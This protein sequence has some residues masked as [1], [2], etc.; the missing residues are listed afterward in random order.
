MVNAPILLEECFKRLDL[1]E[2]MLQKMKLQG[3]SLTQLYNEKKRVK[4]ELKRYDLAFSS[5][6]DRIPDR[7]EK[8]PMRP[9][10]IYYKDLKGAI[11]RLENYRKQ[12]S[13]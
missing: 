2:K 10:Y 3:H 5:S 8:E 13:E 11:S 9:L 7:E 4:N 6:F 1:T 12:M